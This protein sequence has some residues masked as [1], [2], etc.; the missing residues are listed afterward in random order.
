M[1][2]D[3]FNAVADYDEKFDFLSIRRPGFKTTYSL[4][5]G[6]VSLDFGAKNFIG[7]E[8]QGASQWLRDLFGTKIRPG[9]ITGAKIALSDLHALAKLS[10]VLSL[11]GRQQVSKELILQKQEPAPLL[12]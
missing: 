10:L 3:L 7:V 9:D 11:G 1:K 2:S 4:E 8:I 5:L 6:S 12:A